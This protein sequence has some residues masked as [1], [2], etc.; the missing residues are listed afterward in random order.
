MFGKKRAA[1]AQDL[2]FR[3][4]VELWLDRA[5]TLSA[6][7]EE[8]ALLM[9]ESFGRDV[10]NVGSFLA[11]VVGGDF[12]AL[13]SDAFWTLPTEG[14][15]DITA[16]VQFPATL[17]MKATDPDAADWAK[18]FI[19]YTENGRPVLFPAPYDFKARATFDEMRS[20][21]HIPL[22][23]L[24]AMDPGPLCPYPVAAALNGYRENL[25]PEYALE[26]GG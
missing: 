7:R 9:G 24:Q 26:L 25:P 15:T 23:Y 4:F 18:L 20:L 13:D 22:A 17:D 14:V 5:G 3:K 8:L 16:I 11:A 21:R 12:A 2:E 6:P 19:P 10:S 1:A